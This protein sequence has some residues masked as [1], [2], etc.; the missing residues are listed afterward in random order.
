LAILQKKIGEIKMFALENVFE[1]RKETG[2]SK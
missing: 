1:K 2:E